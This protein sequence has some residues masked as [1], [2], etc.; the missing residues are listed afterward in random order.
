MVL[1]QCLLWTLQYNTTPSETFLSMV[2]YST[3]MDED[4]FNGEKVG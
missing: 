1:K 2:N 4:M 3:F